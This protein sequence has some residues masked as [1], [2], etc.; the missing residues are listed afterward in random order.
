V[1]PLAGPTAGNADFAAYYDQELGGSTVRI[2]NPFDIVPRAWNDES[3]GKLADLYEPFTRA[4]PVERGAIDGLR[5]VVKDE[6]Y[7]QIDAAQPSLSGAVQSK[8]CADWATQAGWQHHWGYQC[9]LGIS[10][11]PSV[12]GCPSKTKPPC[13]ATCPTQ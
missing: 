5:S 8:G 12:Q 7:T 10:V 13:S 2:W 1:Y 4:D 6:G 3:M 9:A 11:N